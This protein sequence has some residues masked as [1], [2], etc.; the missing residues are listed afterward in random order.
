MFGGVNILHYEVS[1][2]TRFI[3]RTES[4]SNVGYFEPNRT[5]FKID[6]TIL[7]RSH[8]VMSSKTKES[9]QDIHLVLVGKIY[10]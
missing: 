9:R 10:N 6:K 3:H 5:A 4:K 1:Q 2:K 7:F 8:D